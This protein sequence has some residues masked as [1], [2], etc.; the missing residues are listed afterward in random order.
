MDAPAP[1]TGDRIDGQCR[2]SLT[3]DGLSASLHIVP[4]QNGGT[5]VTRDDVLKALA[6]NGIG[7]GVLDEA[8]EAAVA[9][10]AVDGV[11][12]ARGRLPI[13]G[14]DGRIV[15]VLPEARSRVPRLDKAGHIDYRDLG[16]IP[17]VHAGDPL[18][19]REPPTSGIPGRTLLGEVLPAKAGKD[20]VFAPNLAGTSFPPDDA[21]LLIAAIAGQPVTVRGGMIVEPVYKVDAVSMSSG[22]IDFDGSV[23]VRG[24][25][26]AG[27]TIRATGDIEVG[28]VVEMASL[29]AGGNIVIKGGALGSLGRQAGGE[30]ATR[31][32]GQ[33]FTAAYV[34]QARVEAGDSIFI[35]DMAM[36]SELMAINHIRVGNRKRG[37]IVGGSAHAT[38]SITAKV[39][40]APTRVKTHLEIGVNPLMHK[41]LLEMAKQRDARENQLLEVGKL[42]TLAQQHPGRIGAD[43]VARARATAAALSTAIAELREEHNL[44]MTKIELSQQAR[45]IAEQAIYEG[46]EVVMGN[47]RYMLAG[48]HSA[49]AIGMIQSSLGRIT[50]DDA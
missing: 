40:G 3:A 14:D 5:P 24:D 44:L 17:M 43:H 23:V 49:C 38:L 12:V 42:L 29:E 7:E 50:L 6:E 20:V 10:G 25:V 9:A 22:N 37:H 15:P 26:A 21:N 32:C 31:R 41:Q 35:D 16:E 13:D 27:M 46:V 2:I 11:T 30:E 8:V 45:V 39:I 48:E 33:C 34:Q 19:R 4:P 47:L 1:S 28:G 18:L 36:Q